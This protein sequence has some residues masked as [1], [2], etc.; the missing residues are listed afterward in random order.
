MVIVQTLG[1]NGIARN[2]IAPLV[3]TA[4][5]VFSVYLIVQALI[6][7]R[8]LFTWVPW[9]LYHEV[10]ALYYGTPVLLIGVVFGLCGLGTLRLEHLN[11]PR[12]RDHLR[13]CVFLYTGLL[14]MVVLFFVAFFK[15]YQD[16]VPYLI[17]LAGIVPAAL[18]ILIDASILLFN[19][20]QSNRAEYGGTR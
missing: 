3:Y 20:R 5:Y 14:L 10:P 8:L 19:R 6:S 4:A 18:G 16:Q 15:E 1:F 12:L 13:R 11:R 9:K 17:G 2:L 7:G